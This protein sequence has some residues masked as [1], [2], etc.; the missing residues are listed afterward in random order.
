[1]PGGRTRSDTTASEILKCIEFQEE[2]KKKKKWGRCQQTPG[3]AGLVGHGRELNF[4]LRLMV[5]FKQKGEDS[6]F[7]SNLSGYISLLSLP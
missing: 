5:N 4:I 1:M 7:K 2:V 3:Y 6:R